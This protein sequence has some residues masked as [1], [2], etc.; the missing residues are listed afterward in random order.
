M[1]EKIKA[2][3]FVEKYF[4]YKH[5]AP[6]LQD[7]SKPFNALA[8]VIANAEVTDE[9]QREIALQKLLEAKD[10][11]VR[12]CIMIQKVDCIDNPMRFAPQAVEDL[13]REDMKSVLDKVPQEELDKIKVTLADKGRE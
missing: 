6:Q 2:K 5:L 3:M 11:F 10:C 9:E 1:A 13:L 12:S 8:G 7:A 4:Q